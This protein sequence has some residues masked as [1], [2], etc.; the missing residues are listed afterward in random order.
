[1]RCPFCRQEMDDGQ[2]FRC[3]PI[4]EKTMSENTKEVE[5]PVE[6]ESTDMDEL[7]RQQQEESEDEESDD[8]PDSS[9]E[10]TKE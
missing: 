1:M 3:T 8:E 10:E 2:H 7:T 4:K 5:K 6:D 9:I